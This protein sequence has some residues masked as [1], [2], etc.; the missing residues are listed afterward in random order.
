MSSVSTPKLRSL[1]DAIAAGRIKALTLDTS[2]FDR[3]SLKLESGLLRRLS[4]FSENSVLLV[5][6]D[7]VEREV[8]RHI[9][10]QMLEV[11]QEAAKCLTK[12]AKILTQ[13]I[14]AIDDFRSNILDKRDPHSH[15]LERFQSFKND[16][17]LEVICADD[18]VTVD[19]LMHSYFSCEPP[20]AASGS[21]KYEFPDAVTLF[22]IEAWAKRENG[23]VLAVSTDS[24]WE[25][26][27]SK[28]DHLELLDDL[29]VA[30]SLFQIQDASQ[31]C[32]HLYE[33]YQRGEITE[34]DKYINNAVSDELE[35][36]ELNP[37]AVS[38]FRHELD[39][40]TFE[41]NTIQLE[42]P[43]SGGIPF[44]PVQFNESE[45]TVEASVTAK[46]SVDFTFSFYTFDSVDKEDVGLGGGCS[47]VDR[48]LSF[49]IL[50]TLSGNLSN[51]GGIIEI[52]DIEATLLDRPVFD[53]GEIEPDW[54]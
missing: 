2:I 18:Y 35:A 19:R 15:A 14:E 41:V 42:L 27:C 8:I 29:S 3:N 24:D 34:F 22:A 51:L 5:L 32:I 46:V 10:T 38:N 54:L 21:K 28:S 50:I 47:S 53:C 49:R 36:I 20:F 11:K 48:L 39:N 43:K 6:S 33:R 52:E 23:L 9:T 4:Q 26:F 13:E 12:L 17:G 1:K 25:S 30:L 44:K 40:T 16:T 37:I 7:V 31:A 45:I